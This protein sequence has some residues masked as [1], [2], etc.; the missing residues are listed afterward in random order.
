MIKYIDKVE[1]VKPEKLKGFFVGWS[2]PPSPDEHLEILK[3]SDYVILAV[4]E[5]SRNVVGFINALSDKTLYSYIPLLE[6][7]P[8]YQG[9]GIAI[10][11]MNLMLKKLK[12]YYAIDVCCDEELASFYKKFNFNKVAGM[13]KRNYQKK[14]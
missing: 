7:L 11:L 4:D 8:E 5:K 1:G 12:Q 6:V 14:Q 9:Q 13:I 3:N 10:E 2:N